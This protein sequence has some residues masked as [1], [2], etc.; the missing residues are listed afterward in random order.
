MTQDCEI[1]ALVD[2]MLKLLLRQPIIAPD[3]DA[4]IDILV[5]KAGSCTTPNDWRAAVAAALAAGY[6]QEPVILSHGA[7]HCHWRLELTPFG[8]EAAARLL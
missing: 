1:S 4:G 6:I 3:A 7:L 5:A 8:I 2:V